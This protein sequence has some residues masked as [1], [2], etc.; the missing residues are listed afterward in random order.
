M[1]L[2]PGRFRPRSG[3]ANAQLG[4]GI[5]LTLER[6]S[7]ER[8]QTSRRFSAVRPASHCTP[9]SL[10]PRVSS[11]SAKHSHYLQMRKHEKVDKRRTRGRY[12]RAID[13]VSPPGVTR[14][15]IRLDFGKLSPRIT[16]RTGGE[17]RAVVYRPSARNFVRL[18]HRFG[19]T[20]RRDRRVVDTF[21]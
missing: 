15:N 19:N 11:R 20:P 14:R 17:S 12:C 6:R 21:V 18:L 4:D 8:S 9:S 7:S 5:N 13:L 1:P 3:E 16:H 10:S 2:D